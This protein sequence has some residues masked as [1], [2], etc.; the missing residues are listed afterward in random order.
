[1]VALL[2]DLCR[3]RLEVNSYQGEGEVLRL[4]ASLAQL[5]ASAPT[6]TRV[7]LYYHLG[8]AELFLGLSLIHI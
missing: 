3:R 1:M 4:K 8:V 2:A 6:K 5:P 7:E